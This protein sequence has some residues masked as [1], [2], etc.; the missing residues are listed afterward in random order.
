[1]VKKQ[2]QE[3][4]RDK[5]HGNLTRR[6]ACEVVLY[7]KDKN[8]PF[9]SRPENEPARTDHDEKNTS[10]MRKL[11][12]AKEKSGR[13]RERRRRREREGE[14]EVTGLQSATDSSLR[15]DPTCF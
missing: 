4:W 9:L 12:D 7:Y 6:V 5:Q 15:K 14:E 8:V 3:I 2:Q 1:M 10:E 11:G 13:K